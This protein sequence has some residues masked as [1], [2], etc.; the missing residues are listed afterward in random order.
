MKTACST[1]LVLAAWLIAS[2]AA[3]DEVPASLAPYMTVDEYR[4][5]GLHRLTP[6]ERASFERWLLDTLGVDD[7]P[8]DA[9]AAIERPDLEA[10]R[11]ALADEQRRLEAE[12]AA[13][14]RELEAERRAASTR[15]EPDP[16]DP[17]QFGFG[18]FAT[19]VSAIEARLPG[20][21]TGWMP[22]T[23]F[24][25]DNGQ[26]WESIGSDTFSP[27]SPIDS[28]TVTIRRRMLGAFM[29][30]VEGYNAS[31]RVRRIE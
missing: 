22:G 29:L 18:G 16:D 20:R 14:R 30:R 13:A 7:G 25:L 1:V 3:A 21:F 4:A 8:A 23:R 24:E 19:G 17:S 11:R 9:T 2:P 26:V 10:E 15:Q 5:A 31:V 6:A 28:P 27:V 12:L